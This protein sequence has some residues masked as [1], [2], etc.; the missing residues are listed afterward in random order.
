MSRLMDDLQ[1]NP[2]ISKAINV[3]SQDLTP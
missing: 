2:K 1:N 3:L